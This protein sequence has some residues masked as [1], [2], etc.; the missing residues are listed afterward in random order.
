MKKLCFIDTE[1]TG[2]DH[3]EHAMIQIA[4]LIEID[5][6]VK[7]EFNFNC[8][9]RDGQLIDTSAIAV[10]GVTIE[11]I[12]GFESPQ[13]VYNLL[14]K[15]FCKYVDKFNKRDKFHFVGYN[16][17]FD[18][19]FVRS[20]FERAGDKYFGS[21]FWYPIIDIAVL[22]GQFLMNER[23]TLPNFQLGTVASHLGIKAEG[24][25]HDALT[26]IKLAR[27]VYKKVV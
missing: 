21:F 20:F 1:T 27:E 23:S 3:K 10:S 4:G 26:D 15:T 11:Q 24:A 14:T 19:N 25:L 7:E 16:G 22:A 8:K 6:E 9:P 13:V 2:L 18:A 12:Q 17:L 5:G